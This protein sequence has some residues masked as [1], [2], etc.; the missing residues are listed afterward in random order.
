MESVFE[1]IRAA[2][3]TRST[4][5]IQGESG[6]GKE[7]VARAIHQN[8]NRA[9]LPFVTVNSGSLPPD[10]LESHL[11]GHVKGAFTGAVNE[12]QGL[13]EAAD[14][15]TIFFDEISSIG[16]ETQA[17]LLR[18]MQEREFMRLGGTK[19]IQ[20]DV[21]IIAATNTDLEELIRQ[22]TFRKDLYLPAERHQDRAAAPAR[23][24]RRTSRILVKH[25]VDIYA[26]ENGKEIEGVSEDVLE[27]LEKQR[28]AGQRPGAGEPDRAGGR[29]R[30][31]PDHHPGEPA[32]LPAGAARHGGRR[33]RRLPG[34][35]P[36]PQG[37]DPGLPEAADR[38]L[39]RPGQGRPEDGRRDARAEADDPQRDDQAPAGSTWTPLVSKSWPRHRTVGCSAAGPDTVPRSRSRE[40]PSQDYAPPP[41]P[42]MGD[43]LLKVS[44]VRADS[45]R[46]RGSAR[47]RSRRD[48]S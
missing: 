21:R 26:K 41:P 36:R 11:F 9:G 39:A 2:A 44:G 29:L 23:P 4:I 5:L 25:F 47:G 27:I 20:V 6:T 19:T 48:R 13:F 38:G 17:K 33:R 18:V 1:L 8:S 45:R 46:F 16:L 37:A 40:R 32:G 24:A 28:L 35:R 3:P 22:K 42:A 31:V 34:G 12:K 30:Q 15:G 14:E 43:G 10:L 7:L